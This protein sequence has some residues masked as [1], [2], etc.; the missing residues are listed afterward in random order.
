MPLGAVPSFQTNTLGP[1]GPFLP[2]L[3]APPIKA[4]T[5]RRVERKPQLPNQSISQESSLPAPLLRGAGQRD[6][7]PPPKKH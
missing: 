4:V 3:S 5:P 2:L 6:Q 1:A 7:P